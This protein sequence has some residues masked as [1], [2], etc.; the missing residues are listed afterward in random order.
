MEDRS[1]VL[2]SGGIDSAACLAIEADAGRL[3]SCLFVHYGQPA[4]ELEYAAARRLAHAAGAPLFRVDMALR[5]MDDMQAEPGVPGARV[6]PG[7]NMVLLSL[8]ANL[9]ASRGAS[10]VVLGATGGDEVGYPDCRRGFVQ[11]ANGACAAAG[12]RVEAPLLSLGK[13]EVVALARRHKLDLGATWSCYAPSG[14]GAPCGGCDS[15]VQR[16]ASL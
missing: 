5:G 11:A 14:D 15:C 7:R 4:G 6:V 8:A 12:V 9:A 16:A 10:V 3:D 2:L 13:A 1:V